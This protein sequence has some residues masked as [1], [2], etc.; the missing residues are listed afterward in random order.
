[1]NKT[2]DSVVVNHCIYGLSKLLIS[3]NCRTY[4]LPV[5]V[6]QQDKETEIVFYYSDTWTLLILES[7]AFSFSRSFTATSF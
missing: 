2:T 6:R 1:M 3:S 7:M 4:H 5:I